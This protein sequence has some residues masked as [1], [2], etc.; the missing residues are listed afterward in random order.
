MKKLCQLLAVSMACLILTSM[1]MAQDHASKEE[2]VSK[3]KEAAALIKAK[4]LDGCIEAINDPKG[5]FVWKD[6]YV[7]LMDLDGKILAHPVN[8]KLIGKTPTVADANG[9]MF[10]AEFIAVGKSQG[11]GW[12]DYMWPKPGEQAPSKKITYVY[13]APETNVIVL[14]GIY[15]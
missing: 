7:F 6:T 10:S 4:G 1:A 13:R 14:S 11:E 2:V 9:K 15:E 5:A 3:V 12:V 8:A